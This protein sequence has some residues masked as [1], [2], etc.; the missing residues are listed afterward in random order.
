M[1][2]DDIPT[3]L[4]ESAFELFYWFSRFEFALKQRQ[5]LK[6]H[7]PGARAE[8]GWQQFIKAWEKSYELTPTGA[9]L[10]E[11]NPQRQVVDATGVDLEFVD[12]VFTPDA[13][14]LQRVV[15]LAQTVRNN[16]FHGGKHGDKLWDDPARMRQL[17]P[18]VIVVLNELAAFAGMEDDY[19]RYY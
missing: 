6:D 3:D 13:S 2:H 17:L 12:L 9:Q 19:Y 15:R 1:R 11:A 8:P 16:L 7:S 18:L 4:R 14:S 5:Y 10:I